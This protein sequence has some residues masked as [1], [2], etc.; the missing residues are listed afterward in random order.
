MEPADQKAA[1][2]KAPE[3]TTS[4]NAVLKHV[5]KVIVFVIGM[6]V[7][8]IGIAMIVLPG[9]ATVVVPVGLAILATEFVWA[10]RWLNYVKQRARD[11]AEWTSNSTMP[12]DSTKPREPSQQSFG[13]N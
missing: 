1:E 13:G 9:P 8:L 4:I 2:T 7:L 3:S 6:S 10:R 5:R 11:V 12:R